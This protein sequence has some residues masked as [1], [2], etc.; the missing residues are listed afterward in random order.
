MVFPKVIL[1]KNLHF[2]PVILNRQQI[3]HCQMYNKGDVAIIVGRYMGGEKIGISICGAISHP[4]LDIC[5]L[6][7]T[8]WKYQLT[9]IAD[10]VTKF[11][12]NEK[13]P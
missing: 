9:N 13:Y 3:V 10:Y 1:P 12:K 6:D 7:V 2:L 8:Y 11:I 4:H 5:I